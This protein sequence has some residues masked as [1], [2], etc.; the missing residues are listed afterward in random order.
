MMCAANAAVGTWIYEEEFGLITGMVTSLEL[1][2]SENSKNK[3]K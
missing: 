1:V 3:E 2:A